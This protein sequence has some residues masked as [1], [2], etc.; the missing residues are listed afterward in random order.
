MSECGARVRPPFVSVPPCLRGDLVPWTPSPR[1]LNLRS[2][3]TRRSTS[4]ARQIQWGLPGD[5]PVISID[6][7][8][9]S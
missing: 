3:P 2:P 7:R 6:R 9:G 8:A 4:G 5:E 1:L